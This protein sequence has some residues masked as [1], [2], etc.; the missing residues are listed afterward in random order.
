M[1]REEISVVIP[2]RNGGKLFPECI[3][4]WLFQRCDQ[5]VEII[6]IDSGSV[7]GTWETICS[8]PVKGFQIDASDFNHG[9]T[10]NLG[11]KKA[12]GE[13]LIF[14]VADAIPANEFVIDYLIQ[15]FKD[16]LV[17][18][19]SGKQIVPHDPDKNP[20][21]WFRPSKPLAPYQSRID[22]ASNMTMSARNLRE[23]AGID[24]VCAAYRAPLLRSRPFV[25]ATFGEDLEWGKYALESGWTL[26]TD[27]RAQVHHYHHDNG[28]FTYRRTIHELTHEYQLFN[29]TPDI[30]PILKKFPQAF[31]HLLSMSGLT[32]PARIRWI[33]Y[34]FRITR[35]RLRA[36]LDFSKAVRHG[37]KPEAE[38]LNKTVN[39]SAVQGRNS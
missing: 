35:A 4:G 33:A 23:A 3:K 20:M 19:V 1:P 30:A 16:P 25:H 37:G 36:H 12:K 5:P 6:V 24:N 31:W 7:D 27:P 34:N 21:Q 11:V 17:A 28:D 32:I 38:Q 29:Y 14:T 22:P 13:I 9:S 39:P 10:R 15:H 2:V 26:V 8:L 18:A